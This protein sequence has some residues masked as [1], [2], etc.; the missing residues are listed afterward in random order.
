MCG[1]GDFS[2]WEVWGRRRREYGLYG[3]ELVTDLVEVRIERMK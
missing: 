2:Y 3:N 1:F